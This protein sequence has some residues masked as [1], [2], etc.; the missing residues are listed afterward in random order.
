MSSIQT[1]THTK[2]FGKGKHKSV[3]EDIF[4][5]KFDFRPETSMQTSLANALQVHSPVAYTCAMLKEA[6]V[7]FK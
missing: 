4:L 3:C 6:I 2:V 7:I 5:F 1:H